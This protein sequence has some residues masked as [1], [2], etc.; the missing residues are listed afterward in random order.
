MHKTAA[1]AHPPFSSAAL[2]ALAAC[3]R[4]NAR[5]E[6]CWLC[7]LSFMAARRPLRASVSGVRSTHWMYHPFSVSSTMHLPSRPRYA[8]K[9]PSVVHCVA[10]MWMWCLSLM[11]SLYT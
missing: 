6:A 1:A 9:S 5:W 10:F 4:R 8:M 7:S 2:R 3:L 11:Y